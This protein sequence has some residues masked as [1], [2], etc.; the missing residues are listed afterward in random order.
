MCGPENF[1][2]ILGVGRSAICA[3]IWPYN[4]LPGAGR[5]PKARFTAGGLTNGTFFAAGLATESAAA[6]SAVGLSDTGSVWAGAFRA[7]LLGRGPEGVPGTPP[8]DAAGAS[9]VGCR[10]GS[11]HATSSAPAPARSPAVVDLIL[12][13]ASSKIGISPLKRTHQLQVGISPKTNYAFLFRS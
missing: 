11:L 10:A 9:A 1:A 2:G 3:E 8:S 12:F 4:L 5:L 13:M 7:S 6:A